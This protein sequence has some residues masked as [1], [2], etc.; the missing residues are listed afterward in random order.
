MVQLAV[1][2][3]VE[4]VAV[5]KWGMVQF[6]AAVSEKWVDWVVL[7]VLGCGSCGCGEVNSKV[8]WM[9]VVWWYGRL[10]LQLVAM[11]EWVVAT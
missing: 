4:W 8:E 5:V 7:A 11:S 1:V 9:P 6:V 2:A 10:Q 3:A